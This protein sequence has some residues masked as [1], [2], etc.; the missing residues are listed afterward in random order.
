MY[1]RQDFKYAFIISQVERESQVFSTKEIIKNKNNY[2]TIDYSNNINN[3]YRTI[4]TIEADKI[5]ESTMDLIDDM[6]YK[7][8]FY[9]RLYSVGKSRYLQ[10]ADHCR[11]YAKTP[12]KLF[13]YMLKNL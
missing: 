6:S 4:D 2:R 7:P 12:S 9:K 13:V 3:N 5:V 10:T 11:K 1:D 8:F